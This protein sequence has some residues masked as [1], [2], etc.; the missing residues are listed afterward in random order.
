VAL[1]VARLVVVHCP[2]GCVAAAPGG[3]T[4]RQ[5]SVRLPAGEIR[6]ATGAGDAVAAGVLLGL[7]EE[8]PVEDC[9][10]LG[11]SAAAASLRGAA[12]GDA[13]LPA[14]D[15]LALGERLGFRVT[16]G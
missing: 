12:T 1:G 15:C 8:W 14:A 2:A 3:R 13:I 9:L 16:T 6:N 10:R 4:W 5:G 11:M 7:H